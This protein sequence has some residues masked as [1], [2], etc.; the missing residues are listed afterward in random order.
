MQCFSKLKCFILVVG[1]SR[2]GST[3]LGSILDAHPNA[4]IANESRASTI[5]WRDLNRYEILNEISTHAENY[6]TNEKISEGYSYS[7]KNDLLDE[8]DI[9]VMGDKIWNPATLILHGDYSLLRRLEDVLEVPIKIIHA[10]RNPFDVIATMHSRSK[11]PIRDRILWYFMHCDSVKAINEAHFQN[12]GFMNVHH[13]SLIS[14][15]TLTLSNLCEFMGLDS[16]KYP[17]ESF[18]SMLFKEPKKTRLNINWLE[19][20]V[21]MIINK[22]SEYVFLEKYSLED[23]SDLPIS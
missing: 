21:N 20:D 23:Y 12:E 19:E 8:S 3:L 6:R 13:E 7:I 10:I 16:N 22:M 9:L 17:T 2:S 4:N 18:K 11:A 14:S 1:N 5:F 15:P